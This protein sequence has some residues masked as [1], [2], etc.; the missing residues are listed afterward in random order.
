MLTDE[1]I[2]IIENDIVTMKSMTSKA[3]TELFIM[4]LIRDRLFDMGIDFQEAA[5]ASSYSNFFID[6]SLESEEDVNM[7][8]N[9]I[10]EFVDFSMR[11]ALSLTSQRSKK[12][13]NAE[14]ALECFKQMLKGNQTK[15]I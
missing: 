11:R 5:I 14:V 3:D 15:L 2:E 13:P 6:F 12:E 9:Y 4:K 8:T 7:V 1:N 10:N